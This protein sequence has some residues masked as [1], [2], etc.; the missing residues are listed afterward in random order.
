G[1]GERVGGG[2]VTGTRRGVA[3]EPGGATRMITGR[4]P[5]AWGGLA[6][7]LAAMA[8]SGTVNISAWGRMRAPYVPGGYILLVAT[9]VR[10]SRCT[11]PRPSTQTSRDVTWGPGAKSP[12]LP[13]PGRWL[14]S[15]ARSSL[16][17]TPPMT[18]YPATSHRAEGS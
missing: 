17:R 15:V 8:L 12:S 13:G 14:R 3:G 7:S 9:E 18:W 10:L 16:T 11:T 1:V 5:K 4:P 2:V 6:L